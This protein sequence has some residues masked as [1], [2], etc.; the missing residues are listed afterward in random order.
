MLRTSPSLLQDALEQLQQATLDHA[1]WR[2]RLVRV[3]SGRHP[4]DP[5]DLAVD[6]HRHCTFGQ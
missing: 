6:A 2:D 4:P 1:E 5:A 3:I